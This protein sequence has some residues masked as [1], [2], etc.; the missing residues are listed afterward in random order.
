MRT[1][2][3]IIGA[4]LAGLACAL[5]CGADV[6][7]TIVN[8]TEPATHVASAWAQGGLAAALGAD[9]TTALHASDTLAAAAGIA[10]D[11]TVR[12]LTADAPAAIALLERFGVPFDRRED[13][14]LALGLEAAHSRRRIVHAADHTGATIVRSLLDVVATRPN[15]TLR[16]GL[17]SV[18]LAQADDGRVCGARFVDGDGSSVRIDA[19]AVVLASGGYGGLYARTTTPAATLGAGIAMARR[20]GATLADLEFVQFHPTALATADDPMA[21]VSEAVRGEGASLVDERGARFV[22]ELA[23]RD[24]VARAIFAVEERGGHAYLDARAALGVAFADRFPT[25]AA[26]CA[27]AGIDPARAPIPVTPAAHY[28]IGGVVTDAHGRCDLP[29]L[30]ACG[31]VAATGLHGANRLA[32]NSLMEALIFGTRAARDIGGSAAGRHPPVRLA[33]SATAPLVGDLAAAIAPLR[34]TMNALVGV[35]RDADG[36]RSALERFAAFAALPVVGDPRVRDALAVARAVTEAALQ[37]RES[38]GTHYRRDYPLT[39]PRLSARS[40]LAAHEQPRLVA[41]TS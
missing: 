38:R 5:E 37:R 33:G 13:G 32:S 2:V 26:R 39:E 29:G 8:D 6:S 40:F 10:D 28:T 3:L 14:S 15:V 34:A 31:E 19:R 36:L 41:R 1:D 16:T 9:D 24:V 21:L 4:G 27:A 20:A 25:I 18:D 12:E 11:R 30:W 7:V 23:P 35:V 22:D 17:R